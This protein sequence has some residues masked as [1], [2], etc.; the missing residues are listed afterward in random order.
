MIGGMSLQKILVISSLLIIA[1]AT[2]AQA[3]LWFKPKEEFSGNPSND[4]LLLMSED[5]RAK[6]LSRAMG[7][8]C[9]GIDPY[10]MGTEKHGVNTLVSFWS[11]TC[12]ENSKAQFMIVIA[13]DSIGSTRVI[14]CNLL[15]GK[16]WTCYEQLKY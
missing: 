1:I 6:A 11:I 9:T 7:N 15:H 12:K 14:Q 8:I 10:Y 13:P 5:G 16:P 3:F 2:P 4:K